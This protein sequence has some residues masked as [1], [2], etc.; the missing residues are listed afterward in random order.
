MIE[1]GTRFGRL[2]VIGRDLCD[3]SGHGRSRCLCDCG[4]EHVSQNCSLLNGRIRSCGCLRD[5]IA[6][7]IARI[8]H[9][10]HGFAR[11]GKESLTW[12]SW[13]M[14]RVRCNWSKYSKWKDYG[15]RGIKV[16][17]R[18]QN[19]FEAFLQDMGERPG[20]EYSIDRIDTNGNYEPGNCRWAT[21]ITQQR[22]RRNV[23]INIT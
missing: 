12:N 20:P 3:A 19:S 15:G 10:R 23:R 4:R 8:V 16:C 17:E 6:R 1:I 5:D 18:W 14:M 11:Q 9:T 13:R 2:T 7:V 21:Q 22:N